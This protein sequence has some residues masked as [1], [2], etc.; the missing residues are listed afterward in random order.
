VLSPSLAL[1]IIRILLQ[2]GVETGV[3]AAG[4]PAHLYPMSSF[5]LSPARRN[6]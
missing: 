5:A 3:G 6:P 1:H 4:N 2:Q